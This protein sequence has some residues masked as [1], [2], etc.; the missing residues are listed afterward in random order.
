VPRARDACTR[1]QAADKSLAD[2]QVCL[3]TIYTGT[4]QNEQ[5]V[6]AFTLALRAEPESDAAYRGLAAAQEQLL[7]YEEAEKTFLRAVELRPHYWE[8]RIWLGAFYRSRARYDEAL[9]QY[10]QAV[11]LSPDNARA[12]ALLGGALTLAGRYAEAVE[13][14]R[15]SIAIAPTPIAYANWGMT[16]Y[17]QRR[18]QEAVGLLEMADA[19]APDFRR[20]GSLARACYWAGDR[21]RALKLFDDT[22]AAGRRELGV[23][24]KNTDVVL[25]VAE[26]LAKL[27]RG[28]EAIATLRDATLVGPHER[29][30]AALTYIQA[31]DP[32]RALPLLKDA[33]NTGLPR[34][35]LAAWI[36]LDPLRSDP[37]FANLLK[38]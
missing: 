37:R 9:E 8:G 20:L 38:Q 22:L 7:R 32:D 23:N 33:I 14:Y 15:R 19:L 4:G 31:G 5:A 18:F 17:R 11:L 21:Q 34:A 16:A 30:F 12:H 25:T 3:G 26:A 29:Y 2:A 28:R 24:P 10:R 13:A 36:E 35:E 1:A 6:A 27:G